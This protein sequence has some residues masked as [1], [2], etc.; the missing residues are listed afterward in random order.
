MPEPSQRDID[1]AWAAGLFE[2]EGSWCVTRQGYARAALSSTDHDVAARFVAI[3]GVGSFYGPCFGRPPS[4][5]PY[6]RWTATNPQDFVHFAQLVEGQLGQR[7]LARL[8]EIRETSR[9]SDPK[10]MARD[11]TLF[12]VPIGE[13][14]RRYAAGESLAHIG[15]EL[16]V[17]VNVVSHR[18]RRHGVILRPARWPQEQGKKSAGYGGHVRWHEHRGIVK[19]GCAYCALRARTEAAND[20]IIAAQPRVE[21]RLRQVEVAS[22]PPAP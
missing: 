19:P 13:A 22:G 6:W 3:V 1:I 14:A 15:R 9:M 10:Y 21:E 18:L 11:R 2:G 4:R 20:P 7:R 5:K 17:S 8:N 16:G 12:D